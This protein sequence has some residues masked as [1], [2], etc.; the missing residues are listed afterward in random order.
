MRNSELAYE[1]RSN[2]KGRII[3]SSGNGYSI[4]LRSGAVYKNITSI[5][6]NLRDGQEVTLAR[7]GDTYTI[8]GVAV[9]GQGA[10]GS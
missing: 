6:S 1:N 10:L 2:L 7:S 9:S 3:G 4:Q 8:I 5:Y